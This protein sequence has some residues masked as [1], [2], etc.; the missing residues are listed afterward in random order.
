M[1]LM[2]NEKHYNTLNEYYKQKYH[3]K[4]CKISLN[5]NF[6]CPNKDGNVG[7][8]GCTYCSKLGSGDFAGDKNKPLKEQFFDIVQ[9][10][11]KK[12]P[13]S[14][15][16]PYLQANSNTYAPLADLKNI[17]EEVI[18]YSDKIVMLSIAT[19]PDCLE[20]DKIQYLAN[21]NK[22]IPVQIELG[23]QTIWEQTAA[24]T[25]RCHSLECLT[26][27]VKKLR[28]K[29]I[30]VVLHIING[31]P[32]ETKEMMLET[33]KYINTLDI[34]G[35]KIHSL[36]ILNDTK[37]GNDY[38]KNP[39]KVLTLEEYT[40]IVVEQ[41]RHLNPNII[42][43]RLAADG[44]ADDLIVPDWTRKKLVVM[45]E[46]DKKMRKLNAYQGDSI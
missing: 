24:L 33:I 43:H 4:V 35:I 18:N 15:Y 7:Y 44:P 31:L 25:N 37:M 12:W 41:I 3:K 11:E 19:R 42:I 20:D 21:L 8:G 40:D 46:I 34:Q 2:N 39:W 16:I 23:L 36:V 6:T 32:Y 29:N 30:E 17:Y 38:L 45:N 13:D 26:S 14:L 9:I 27:C 1:N 5:A 22:K 28:E 10:M